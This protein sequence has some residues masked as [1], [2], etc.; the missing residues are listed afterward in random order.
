MIRVASITVAGLTVGPVWFTQRPESA[1]PEY[2][3]K[4]MDRPVIAALGGSA[5]QFFRVTM[6]Y[7]NA[8]AYFERP[9]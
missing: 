1:F 7:P 2:M 5:L 4:F 3:S 8:I 9:Q 6:D